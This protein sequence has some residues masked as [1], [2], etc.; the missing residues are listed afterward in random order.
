MFQLEIASN[1]IVI[2]KKPLTNLY[3]MNSNTVEASLKSE[4]PLTASWVFCLFFESLQKCTR[5][6]ELDL[7]GTKTLV[8]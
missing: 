6:S 2:A 5:I 7:Y 3:E 4:G 8:Q 1:K